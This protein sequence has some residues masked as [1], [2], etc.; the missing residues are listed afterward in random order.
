MYDLDWLERIQR[1]SNKLLKD[2]CIFK[3]DSAI[4]KLIA[5]NAE[6]VIELSG[7]RLI[8]LEDVLR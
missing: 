3:I 1:I 2:D 4:N 6:T 8:S 7:L 5:Q